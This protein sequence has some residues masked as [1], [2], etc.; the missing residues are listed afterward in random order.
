MTISLNTDLELQLR[1]KLTTVHAALV[2]EHLNKESKATVGPYRSGNIFH[3]NAVNKW[4]LTR[5]G[6]R[7]AATSKMERFCDNS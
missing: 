1:V 4:I 2:T 7:T 6:S 3:H 5:G